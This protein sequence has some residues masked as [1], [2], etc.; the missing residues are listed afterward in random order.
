VKSKTRL[1]LLISLILQQKSIKN[2]RY[3][4]KIIQT[5]DMGIRLAMVCW[6]LCCLCCKFAIGY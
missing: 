3:D 5:F 1:L 2:E 6:S 4:E